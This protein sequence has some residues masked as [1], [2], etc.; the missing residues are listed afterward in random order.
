MNSLTLGFVYVTGLSWL[1]CEVC[2][3]AA[4][5]NWTPLT[6][7]TI[8]FAV[9][10]AILGCLRLSH[11]TVEMAGPIFSILIGLGILVYGFGAF[12]TSFLGGVIRLLGAAFMVVLG[13]F[14][15]SAVGK[16]DESH[17]AH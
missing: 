2:L 9:M 3:S 10:F 4:N 11:R 7:F 1:L 5:G 6:I 8:G 15:F 13:V 17:E 14:A 16:G 12:G